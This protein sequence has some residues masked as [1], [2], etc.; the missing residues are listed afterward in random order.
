MEQNRATTI[1]ATKEG[2]VALDSPVKLQLLDIL[3]EGT[4]SFEELVNQTG[5]AKSTISVHLND[6]EKLNLIENKPS[7]SDKRKKFFV[8]NSQY[9]AHSQKP[10]WENYETHMNNFAD[11]MSNGA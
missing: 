3:K 9:V 7:P 10:M 5:K 8:F 11:L 2:I 1:F 4:T 6:L